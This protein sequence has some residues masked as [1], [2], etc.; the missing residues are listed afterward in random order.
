[1]EIHAAFWAI[2]PSSATSSLSPHLDYTCSPN[3][4]LP[5]KSQSPGHN[6]QLSSVYA[7][8]SLAQGLCDTTKR[9][10]LAIKKPTAR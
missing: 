9:A 3:L 5:T 4:V 7:A 10:P 1:M 8:A 6:R 2:C